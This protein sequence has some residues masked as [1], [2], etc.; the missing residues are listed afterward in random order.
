MLAAAGEQAATGGAALGVGV[1]VTAAS[2][3]AVAG[4]ATGNALEQVGHYLDDATQADDCGNDAEQATRACQG[5]L[6]LGLAVAVAIATTNGA[7]VA[8]A[9]GTIIAVVAATLAVTLALVTLRG[10]LRVGRLRG[11]GN[12][13][14]GASRRGRSISLGRRRIR[15]R[16]RSIG[17]RRRGVRGCRRF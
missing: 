13:W 11:V 3:G 6:G 12:S 15:G 9:N 17:L 8:A 16:L 5:A 10:L 14:W 4:G 1:A 7:A 2:A